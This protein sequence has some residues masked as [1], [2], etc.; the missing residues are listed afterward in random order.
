MSFRKRNVVLSGTAAGEVSPRRPQTSPIDRG[1]PAARPGNASLQAALPLRQALGT[2]SPGPGKS[3][4]G[5]RHRPLRKPTWQPGERTVLSPEEQARLEPE[6]KRIR[7]A[8]AKEYEKILR[9]TPASRLPPL[10]A[11]AR[12]SPYDGRPITSTGT[13]SVDQLLAGYGGLVLGHS[14]LVEEQ[15]TTDF[16]SVLL[17]AYAAEGLVQGHHVHVLG[18]GAG[19]R[20]ELPGLASA[21][22]SSSRG[23][24]A[25][26]AASD[27][28]KIAWRYEALAPRPT[29]KPQRGSTQGTPGTPI[30]TFCHT[31][32]LTKRLAP[33][34][35]KGTLHA[36]PLPNPL[37]PSLQP[38]LENSPIRTFLASISASL[39]S[40]P[41]STIHRV[42]LP[43]FLAPTLYAMDGWSFP[44]VL[45][46]FAG[47]RSLLRDHGRRLTVMLSLSTTL[48]E[49][50]NEYVRQLENLCDNVV[51]LV[52]LPPGPPSAATRTGSSSSSAHNDKSPADKMQGW[53]KVHKLQLYSEIGGA[54]A[55]PQGKSLHE[56]LCFSVSGSKGLV[57]DPYSLPP[58]EDDNGK[59]KSPASTVK[60]GMAF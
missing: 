41:P 20:T 53:F 25:Q 21:S 33:T 44:Y 42:V 56:N 26:D 47:L 57:V 59:E 52:P 19:W 39:A 12:P 54:G 60:D 15:G 38:E 36:S 11:G 10:D 46:L 4:P 29:A 48:Y 24:H 40:T 1:A 7:A 34:D 37:Q 51:E 17:R 58:I 45:G 22:S 14:L 9:P 55:T 31:F 6:K 27:K 13:A 32:D 28:M 23:K 43:S 5:P 2:A 16:A 50:H 35:I 30:A 49:R 3:S 8:L 18:V